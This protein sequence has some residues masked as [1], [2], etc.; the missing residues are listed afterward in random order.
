[1]EWAGVQ[2]AAPGLCRKALPL[3]GVQRGVGSRQFRDPSLGSMANILLIALCWTAT[4]FD[5]IQQEIDYCV[6]MLFDLFVFENIDA[7]CMLNK[8]G[9][10]V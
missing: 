6:D 4:L 8:R 2:A 10:E 5:L 7:K 3:A 1:M 9:H